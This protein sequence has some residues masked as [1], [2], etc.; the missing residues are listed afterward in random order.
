MPPKQSTIAD[1]VETEHTMM[2]EAPQNYGEFFEHACETTLFLSHFIKSAPASR[3][4]FSRFIGQ[5]KKHHTLAIFSTVRL[6]RIQAM[7]DLRQVIEATTCAAYAVANTD[8]ADFVD[9][10]Q[11]GLLDPSQNLAKKRYSWLAKNFPAGSEALLN[12]KNTINKYYGHANLLNTNQN[13]QAVEQEKFVYNFFFDIEDDWV[14]KTDLWLMSSVALGIL[15]LLYGVISQHGGV[16][17]VDDF[18]SCFHKLVAKNTSLNEQLK[19]D[20]RYKRLDK[21]LG[22]I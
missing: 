10:D 17:L 19:D 4:L 11:K 1:M 3:E 6:H 7:M 8:P 14:I 18:G 9:V 12:H 16:V 13:F 21:Q 22:Q 2:L 20:E 15:D 5:V